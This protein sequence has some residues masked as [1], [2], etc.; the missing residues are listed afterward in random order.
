MKRIGN[1]INRYFLGGLILLLHFDLIA[2]NLKVTWNSNLEQDLAGYKIYYGMSS[3]NYSTIIDVGKVTEYQVSSLTEGTQ[4]F[5][6]VTA[7][8]TAKNES[9]FSEEVNTI[10]NGGDKTPPNPPNLV[11]HTLDGLKAF[12]WW[13]TNAE[14]DIAGYKVYYGTFS[15]NYSHV[16]DV[17]NK[18]NFTTSDLSAGTQYF[19]SITAYD[20]SNNESNFSNELIIN[21]PILDITPPNI[22]AVEIS[23][24]THVNVVFSE[25]IDK[26]S[27]ENKVNFSIDHG[28]QI[29]SISLDQN[30]RVV[31]INTS[32]HKSGILYTLVVNNIKDQATNPNV[33]A[34]NSTYNYRFEPEDLSPPFITEVKVLDATHVDV[35]FSEDIER[36]T[37]EIEQNFKIANSI[38]VIS[39]NL[40]NNQRIVHLTTTEHLNNNNYVLTINN[41]R[42]KAPIPNIIAANSTISYTYYE[43]DSTPPGIYSVDIKAENKVD[44][45]FSEVIDQTSAEIATNYLIN[46]GV[47]VSSAQLDGNTQ[48]VHLTTT[49]HTAGLTYII[50]VKNIQDR[51]HPPNIIQ[52]N[53]TFSYTYT[54]ED[55]TPPTILLTNI[56]DGT[57][58]EVTFSEDVERESAEKE[59][60]FIISNGIRVIEA[61]LNE[62]KRTVQL[63]TTSHQSGQT[64]TLMI[65]NIRDRAPSP[66]VIEQNTT[67]MYTYVIEDKT[68]PTIVHAHCINATSVE[69]LFSEIVERES[70][71]DIQNYRISNNVYAMT[72]QLYSDLKTVILTTNNHQSNGTYILTI[73]NIKDRAFPPNV[74]AVNSIYEYTYDSE[75][76]SNELIVSNMSIQN[77]ITGYLKKGDQYYIDRDYVIESIPDE[78]EGLLWIKT[79]NEDRSHTE[80][81]FLSFDLNDNGSIYIAYDS[82]AKQVPDWLSSNFTPLNQFIDVSE[83]ARKLRLWEKAYQKGRVILGG[84]LAQSAQGAESMYLVLARS[85]GEKSHPQPEDNS[86][87]VSLGPTNVFLLYQNYPNPF[88]AGTEI[89][90]QLPEN[91]FVRLTIFNILGQT[92]Q[93][94]VE[95]E[96]QA[97]HHIIHWDG[98]NSEGNNLPSG[99]YF[100]RLEVIRKTT[101]NGKT[102]NQV[103]YNDV[104]KMIYLK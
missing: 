65:N 89:R 102:I 61:I 3:K 39:A 15:R 79:A 101:L 78:Y 71:E 18:I 54:P 1:E 58:V 98:K 74:I 67:T 45:V 68:S 87:P 48:T 100:S 70:A 47:N 31:N 64:Y 104:R 26:S 77:Y 40:D 97:S 59:E 81:E 8:D 30:E 93:H 17:G 53:S 19:F 66:N 96:R 34:S 13:S 7:Y 55:L 85:E 92:I 60:N 23:D 44:V 38:T 76:D 91:C 73:N 83:Y 28:V 11:G 82:R 21:I 50:A 99:V 41:I 94:L 63:I 57:H 4:Y 51:A 88:N 12:V 37:A 103:V 86:D 72:A 16:V 36:V 5:F 10:I 24:S 22:Y 6:A 25:K 90:F 20:L 2:G 95:G 42:D 75:A 29:Y 56:K 84:N 14:S 33:I 80:D 69:V 35:S 62:N 43:I 49:A 52:Q 27:A 46:N 9:S 32:P